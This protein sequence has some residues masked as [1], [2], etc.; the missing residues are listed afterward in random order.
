MVFADLPIA[1]EVRHFGKPLRFQSRYWIAT[2]TLLIGVAGLELAWLT[3]HSRRAMLLAMIGV[4][5]LAGAGCVA[6]RAR[7]DGPVHIPLPYTEQ[8]QYIFSE[9]AGTGFDELLNAHDQQ[10]GV[11]RVF[12][13][14][15]NCAGLQDVAMIRG[16]TRLEYPTF[17][18][19][20]RII[21]T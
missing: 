19:S 5:G 12:G 21:P 3:H 8:Q 15:A 9:G 14:I 6:H 4:T 20:E 17:R 1:A 16:F 18:T 10:D 7:V 11:T 13:A 2:M